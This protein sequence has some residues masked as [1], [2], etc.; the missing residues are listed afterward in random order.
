MRVV[1]VVLNDA[2]KP[3]GTP[4]DFSQKEAADARAAELTAK[5]AE[6]TKPLTQTS[7]GLLTSIRVPGSGEIG[8]YQPR[9]KTA[10]DL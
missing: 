1:W 10:Y 6:F 7:F 8:L 3:V 2:F 9:H 4:F 5:G